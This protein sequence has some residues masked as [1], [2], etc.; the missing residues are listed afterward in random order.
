M[1][2]L[3]DQMAVMMTLNM[4][5]HK[6]IP[7]RSMIQ[8]IPRRKQKER[9]CRKRWMSKSL[10]ILNIIHDITILIYTPARLKQDW[11]SPVYAFYC[12]EVTISYSNGQHAHDFICAAKNCKG[13]GK[14]PRVV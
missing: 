14:N 2:F 11:Q 12:L 3:N 6:I 7:F 4:H 1:Q 13:R 9:N 8:M 5:L 10:V